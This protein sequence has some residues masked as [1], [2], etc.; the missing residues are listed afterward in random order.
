MHSIG[1][2][3]Y[4]YLQKRRSRT[5]THLPYELMVSLLL[6]AP[7][8]AD[9]MDSKTGLAAGLV[10]RGHTLRLESQDLRQLT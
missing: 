8:D 4:S 2:F 10:H 5:R 3:M 9:V 7:D 6:D 1:H